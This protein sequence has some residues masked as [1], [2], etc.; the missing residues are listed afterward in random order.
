[1]GTAQISAYDP[2]AVLALRS[3]LKLTDDQVKEL[4]TIVAT[5]QEQV[6]AK[7]TPEQ[8]ASCNRSTL[9]RAA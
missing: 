3:E 9:L 6:K 2:T 1:M 4:E 7:L 8:L 5:A